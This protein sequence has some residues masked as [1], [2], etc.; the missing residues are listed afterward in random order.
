MEMGDGMALSV[1]LCGFVMIVAVP[2]FVMMIKAVL[3]I[4]A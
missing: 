3:M 1:G 4:R 2:P